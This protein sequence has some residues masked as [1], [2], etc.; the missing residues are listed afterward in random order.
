VQFGG[1]NVTL[2]FFRTMVSHG[3]AAHWSMESKIFPYLPLSGNPIEQE[4][5]Q[6]Q[7]KSP[8]NWNLLCIWWGDFYISEA[9]GF[10][11]LA[12]ASEGNFSVPS[13]LKLSRTVT[14]CFDFVPP[15][16]ESPLFVNVLLGWK[17]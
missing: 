3:C 6:K 11:V 8:M 14:I 9:V 10:V 16:Q 17:L 12:V 7:M 2:I 1:K 15:W 5:P 13:S 4:T